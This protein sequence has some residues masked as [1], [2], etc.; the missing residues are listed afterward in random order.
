MDERAAEI[1]GKRRVKERANM[2]KKNQIHSQ[3]ELV[4]LDLDGNI[5]LN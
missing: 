4:K 3:P 1:N 2:Y 5:K